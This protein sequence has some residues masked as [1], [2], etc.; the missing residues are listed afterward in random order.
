MDL[1]LCEGEHQILHDW[2][3]LR[4]VLFRKKWPADQWENVE[5]L[6]VVAPVTCKIAGMQMWFGTRLLTYFPMGGDYVAKQGELIVVQQGGIVCHDGTATCAYL[7][8]A[9]TLTGMDQSQEFELL[10]RRLMGAVNEGRL[11]LK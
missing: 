11:W 9:A 7:E 3:W 5:E 8:L 10:R 6:S 4:G 1:R 2:A